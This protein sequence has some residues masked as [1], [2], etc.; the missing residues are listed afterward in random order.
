MRGAQVRGRL[1]DAEQWAEADR[2]PPLPLIGD[3]EEVRPRSSLVF[4]TFRHELDEPETLGASSGS[5]PWCSEVA[6]HMR[7]FFKAWYKAHRHN[8]RRSHASIGML[9]V[10]AG[11][12]IGAVTWALGD[13][14]FYVEETMLGWYEYNRNLAWLIAPCG[15]TFTVLLTR[16]FFDGTAGSGS[17]HPA[18][19][20]TSPALEDACL[21]AN[22]HM[23]GARVLVGLLPVPACACSRTAPPVLVKQSRWRWRRSCY[24]TM[25]RTWCASSRCAHHQR[26]TWAETLAFLLAGRALRPPCRNH[27]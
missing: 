3:P 14:S 8:N 17:T 27:A 18:V 10:L 16:L 11:I 19:A 7:N 20:Q 4:A 6:A 21:L 12:L 5:E 23:H 22:A 15:L 26:G 13:A 1:V 9:F 24:S 25:T 2:T